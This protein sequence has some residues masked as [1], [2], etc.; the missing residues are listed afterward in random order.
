MAIQNL[1][2]VNRQ[3]ITNWLTNRGLVVLGL[4]LI[5]GGCT[6]FGPSRPVETLAE[7]GFAVQG[8]LGVRQG[9]EGFSSNF[10]WH[11]TAEGFDIELWGPLG[12]GR[13]RLQGNADGGVRITTAR[14]EVYEEPDTTE[15]MRRW[16]GMAVPLDALQHWIR[17][18]PAPAHGHHW[19]GRRSSVM[20]P[21][22]W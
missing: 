17:G 5:A 1:Q 11:Q 22:S 12:Q 7:T 9:S 14:G 10:S 16:F 13:T 3:M 15:A 21:G 8:K 4:V 18:L 2:C 19:L 6:W 20:K